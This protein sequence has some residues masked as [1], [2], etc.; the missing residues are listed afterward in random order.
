[1]ENV[2]KPKQILYRE[3][4]KRKKIQNSNS[5]FVRQGMIIFAMF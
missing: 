1:M 4:D 2:R 3:R 5:M